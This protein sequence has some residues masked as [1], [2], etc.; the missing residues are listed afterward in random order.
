MKIFNI[1]LTLT[2]LLCLVLAGTTSSRAANSRVKDIVR[3]EGVRKNQLVGY[4]LVIGLNGTGDRLRNTPF[5]EQSLAS[6]LERMGVNV[7]DQELRT[8]NVAAVMV[9]ADL[10][11]FAQYGGTIDVTVAGL[12]DSTS[13]A[14][15]MLLVTPLIG[16]DGEVYAVAQG[17]VMISGFDASGQASRVTKGVP[18][19]GRIA[20]GATIEREIDA[21]LDALPMVRLSLRNPDFTTAV[22]IADAINRHFGTPYAKA[23]DLNKVQIDVPGSYRSRVAQ[24]IY[25]IENLTVAPD[26]VAKVVVDE[27]SGT[28]VIGKDVRIS[29]VAVTQGNL[30]VQINETPQ[31]SQ[32]TPFSQNG[33]TVVVPRT[34]IQVNEQNGN[35]FMILEDTTTLETLVAGLNRLG[36]APRDII[37]ILQAIKVAG[38]LQAEIEVI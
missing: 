29:K 28:I 22:R 24:F 36:M 5:T 15:G 19:T 4:G 6:M 14:G 25:E 31:V 32:P 17:A 7:R 2:T 27:K 8:K 33:Q 35:R 13:L 18:T 3:V 30:T 26:T 16:A 37:A 11:P 23:L 34:D 21:Q 10:P 1:I 9:T 12:G 20:N 38:A